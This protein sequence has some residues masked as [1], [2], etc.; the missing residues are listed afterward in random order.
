MKVKASDIF[1]FSKGLHIK[2]VMLGV[3]FSFFYSARGFSQTDNVT[4]KGNA[5]QYAGFNL[6]LRHYTNYISYNTEELGNFKV[7]ENGNFELSIHLDDI[8]YSFVDLGVLRGSIFLEPGKAYEIILPPYTPMKDADR[9]NPYFKHEKIIIGIKNDDALALNKSINQFDEEYNFLFNKNAFSLFNRG[10]VKLTDELVSRL[11]SLFPDN[12]NKFFENYKQFRY[13]KLYMLSMKRQKNRVISKYYAGSPVC[14]E[15]PAYWETFGL[16]FKDFFSGYFTSKKGK[17]LKQAF[18]DTTGFKDLSSVLGKD[19]LYSSQEFR[20]AVL[21]KALYD[22]FYS[23][24]YDKDKIIFF[25]ESAALLGSTAKIRTLAEELFKKVNHLR[26]GTPAPDFS[27]YNINGKDRTLESYRGR[28][29]Y[30]NF[31][32]TE[33]YTC[34]KD[35]QLLNV[36]SKKLRRDLVIVSIATDRDIKKLEEF[37]KTHKYKWDFL[38]FGDQANVIFDYDI[39]ALPS[40]I[41]IDPEGNILLSPAPAPEE[42]FVARFYETVKDYRYKKLRKERPKEKSIYEF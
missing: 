31:C 15:N 7:D 11:D 41:L 9:F 19:T 18:A 29:V 6:S 1:F 4:I 38:Y 2:I 30:L 42:N 12:G 37:V 27:L 28:F 3:I 5:K 21:L 24:H 34:K 26:I 25:F 40:Y 17:A 23:G 36:F 10:N 14:Y 20:E 13:A 16:L 22:A 39:R 35:F 8:T 33:N 32:N